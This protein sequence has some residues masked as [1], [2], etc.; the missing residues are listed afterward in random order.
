MLANQIRLFLKDKNKIQ[1]FSGVKK[2]PA[3]LVD[4]L[5]QQTTNI[6]NTK[7]TRFWLSVRKKSCVEKEI[8][9][10][11]QNIPPVD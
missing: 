3:F 1:I 6:N 10:E 4:F 5:W 7:N 11:I 8:K 9:K 2:W